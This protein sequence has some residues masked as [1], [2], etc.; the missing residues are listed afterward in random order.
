MF[1][2]E[3]KPETASNQEELGY[4]LQNSEAFALR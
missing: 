2:S 4:V 3:D 1:W